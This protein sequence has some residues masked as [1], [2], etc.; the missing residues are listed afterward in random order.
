MM[1]C[2]TASTSLRGDRRENQDRC[3]VLEGGT[4]ILLLL[5]DG[6]GGHARGELAAATFIDSLSRAFHAYQGT[7]AAVFLQRAF[8][9]AH[10][11]IIAAGREAS[12]PVEPL[13]TGVACLVTDDRAVW[14]HVGDSRLYLLRGDT[15]RVRTIDHSMVEELIQLGE[16]A[17]QD[18]ESHPLR[19]YVTRALGGRQSPVA[20]LSEEMRL[21]PGDVLLLCSDGLWAAQPGEHLIQLLHAASLQD[22]AD[23][24]A[25][26][27][28]ANSTPAS[29]NVTLAAL[30]TRAD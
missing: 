27:A 29:D 3:A 2:E 1:H 9:Q 18:R 28:V 15:T 26:G 14:A 19:N 11:D 23:R 12:P 6:M 4:S 17:E 20:D 8:D 13:T 10:S 5:A 22:C 24:L 25:A 16:L 21:E 30:R 7:D